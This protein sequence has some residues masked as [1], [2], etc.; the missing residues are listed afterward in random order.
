MECRISQLIFL[1]SQAFMFESSM[2]FT[3]TEYAMNR[4]GKLHSMYPFTL[5]MLPF[6][7]ATVHE[8]KM[9]DNLKGQFLNHIDTINADLKAANLP[10][11]G[12]EAK[13]ELVGSK[14]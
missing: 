9:W 1:F 5:L 4:S 11:L 6:D 12:Y 13:N 10:E 2:M 3:I 14:N 8:P 7:A